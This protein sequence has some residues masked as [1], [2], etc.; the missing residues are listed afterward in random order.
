MLPL[1]RTCVLVTIRLTRI[2]GWLAGCLLLMLSAAAV[3]AQEQG[4]PLSGDIQ[5]F[6]NALE[7]VFVFPRVGPVDKKGELVAAGDLTG[8]VR[9]AL[10]NLRLMASRVGV[11]PAHVVTLTLYVKE[12]SAGDSLEKFARESFGDWSPL[13]TLVETK[14]LRVVGA[15]VEVEAVAVVRP[16]RPG[17]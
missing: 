7:T 5:V 13:T 12:K 9:Q 2:C 1:Y 8:Q 3:F 17:R 11:S 6:R 15:L 4:A 10:E 16:L 14:Q